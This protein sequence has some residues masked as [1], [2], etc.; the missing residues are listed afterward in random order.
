MNYSP[1]IRKFMSFLSLWILVLLLMIWC[2]FPILWLLSTSLKNE[3]QAFAIPPVWIFLP[4]LENYKRVFFEGDFMH[5]YMNSLI[6]AAMTTFI[7][8]IFGIPAAYSLN[9]FNFKGRKTVAF[10]IL[11]TRMAPGVGVAIP[12]YLMLR[13]LNLLDT[14][15]GLSLVC[16]TF[17]VG[18][19][20]WMLRGFV[21]KIPKE[22]EE[23]AMVDGCNKWQSFYR[24]VL[25]L[26]TPGISAVMIMS[27]IFTWNEFFYA[28]VFTRNVAKTAP[29]SILGYVCSE[30]IRWGEIGSAGILIILPVF[31]FSLMVGKYLVSGL[32]MGAIKE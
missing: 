20:I 13:A 1:N 2:I 12:F 18:Y 23:A 26:L 31:V 11:V 24:V 32:T 30:G 29:V 7:S 28:L 19:T 10:W 3:V 21:Q 9:R 4:T 14:R 15:F 6:V 17:T 27:F 25:P 5:C 16:L 22:L 8:L